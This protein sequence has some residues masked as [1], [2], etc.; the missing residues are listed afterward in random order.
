MNGAGNSYFGTYIIEYR[1]K[2]HIDIFT[3]T[4]AIENM[5]STL[6]V[7]HSLRTCDVGTSS[8][9]PQWLLM[10]AKKGR[11]N[12][13]FSREIASSKKCIFF[14]VVH[15]I[16]TDSFSSRL[17]WFYRSYPT[18]FIRG[19]KEISDPWL[20]RCFRIVLISIYSC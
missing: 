10:L 4:M 14:E 7:K 1:H 19:A 17:K 2:R 15:A 3:T 12:I 9:L 13:F 6:L 5:L 20:I 16:T 8:C 18:C 11:S